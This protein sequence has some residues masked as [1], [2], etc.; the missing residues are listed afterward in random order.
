MQYRIY[1]SGCL[2]VNDERDG[3]PNRW[4]ESGPGLEP[5]GVSLGV[6]VVGMRVVCGVV[7]RSGAGS[8]AAGAVAD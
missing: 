8:G 2:V 5:A 4:G 6:L 1:E 7:Q 3:L